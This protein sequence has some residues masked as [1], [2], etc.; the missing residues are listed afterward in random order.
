MVAKETAWWWEMNFFWRDFFFGLKWG[1]IIL[2]Y[3][4]RQ[5]GRVPSE[6]F[7]CPLTVRNFVA[8]PD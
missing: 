2:T 7:I 6:T 3:L 8:T 1:S 5:A 4:Q